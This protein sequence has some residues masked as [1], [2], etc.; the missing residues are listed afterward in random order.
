MQLSS[1]SNA[2]PT[3]STLPAR[4]TILLLSLITITTAQTTTPPPSTQPS[5]VSQ[6][7]L[8]PNRTSLLTPGSPFTITWIPDPH[9]SNI[10]LEIWDKTSW[11]YSRDFGDLCYHWVNP[12]C[13][14]IASHA[15]NTGS[16]V[17]QVPK[18]G[19]DYPRD[20]GNGTGEGTGSSGVRVFWIKMYVDDYLKEGYNRDPVLSYS[21]NFAFRGDGDS[22][23]VG[24]TSSVGAEGWPGTS[25]GSWGRGTVTVTVERNGTVTGGGLGVKSTGGGASLTGAGGTKGTGGPTAAV[26]TGGG[27]KAEKGRGTGVW[28]LGLMVLGLW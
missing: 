14:T 18:P 24:W 11:G 9:F 20:A 28:A 26:K 1:P 25:S 2:A 3:I 4:L 5:R 7:I 15:P 21:Q 6:T 23:T 12:F 10:T 16:F 22:G 13:G 8:T 27:G 19:S 17:W